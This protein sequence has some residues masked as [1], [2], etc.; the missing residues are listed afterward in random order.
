MTKKR[1]PFFK[2]NEVRILQYILGFLLLGLGVILILRS[3]LGAGSWDATTANL[4]VLLNATLGMASFSIN[5]VIMMIL[6][7]FHKSMKYLLI[8]VPMI[9]M[10]LTLDFW[11][12]LVISEEFLLQASFFIKVLAYSV[13][14]F[15][16]SLGLALII[17]CDYIAGTID[18]LMLLVMK[19][20]KTKKTFLVRLGIEMFAI[21]LATIFGFSA[22]IGFGAV[23]F[24]SVLA[25]VL[26]PPCLAFHLF[27]L[28]KIIYVNQ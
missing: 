4:S 9:L 22:G 6:I 25:G 15:T 3:R 20:I 11:D 17:S 14:I 8:I 1:K 28:R 19:L 12:I 16:L 2:K 23:N 24:G 13:G 7:T 27:W 5:M 18:E 26:L 21:V 10:S